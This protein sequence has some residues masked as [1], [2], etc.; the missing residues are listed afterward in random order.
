MSEMEAFPSTNVGDSVAVCVKVTRSQDENV[1]LASSGNQDRSE[2]VIKKL[3]SAGTERLIVCGNPPAKLRMHSVTVLHVQSHAWYM[4]STRYGKASPP[5]ATSQPHWHFCTAVLAH[6]WRLYYANDAG[7]YNGAACK[8]RN[9]ALVAAPNCMHWA[10]LRACC[11]VCNTHAEC[12]CSAM[13]EWVMF[14]A[15]FYGIA[16]ASHVP[17]FFGSGF[18]APL[19]S[20]KATFALQ[21]HSKVSPS[22]SRWLYTFVMAGG[23]KSIGRHFCWSD[24]LAT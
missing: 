5:P 2:D 1:T 14:E 20:G 8:A 6:G 22:S 12:F 19:P 9:T 18:P 10:W 15:E 24:F 16:I 4:S 11:R 21:K 17:I 13:A 23:E 3:A 7:S